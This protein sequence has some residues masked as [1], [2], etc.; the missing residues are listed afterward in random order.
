MADFSGRIFLASRSSEKLLGY[1]PEELEGQNLSLLFTEE[2]LAYYYPNILYL[3][4]K[5]NPY[6]GEALLK[7][8]NQALFFAHLVVTP[9]LDVGSNGSTIIFTIHDIDRQKKLEKNF[10]GARHEDLI[11][12]A[13]GIA[14]ELRNP[15]VGVGGFV[16][17]LY[18]ACAASESQEK[19]YTFIM[20]NLKRID[21]LVQKVNYLVSLPTP[22]LKNESIRFMAEAAVQPYL[23]EIEARRIEFYNTL[24]ETR[25]FVDRELVIRL[26]AILLQNALEAV[27]DGSR[28]STFCRQ[29]E[30]NLEI[31]V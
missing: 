2:D 8:K 5:D 30:N 26:L 7:R 24:P 19:Y 16:N 25:L 4:G 31:C 14:H 3:T 22:V 9:C 18:K 1:A 12:V 20:S 27:P 23:K 10:Q 6:H 28:I 13:N 15:L 29:S 21:N 17:R 11:K